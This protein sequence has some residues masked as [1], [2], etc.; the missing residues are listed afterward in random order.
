MSTVL[1][2]Q[3]EMIQEKELEGKVNVKDLIIPNI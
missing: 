2:E 3:Y 1:Y